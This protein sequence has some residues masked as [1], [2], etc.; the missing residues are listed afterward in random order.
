MTS[1]ALHTT[2]DSHG[3][4]AEEASSYYYGLPSKPELL[5]RTEKKQWSAPE[6]HK[7]LFPVSPHPIVHIWNDWAGRIDIIAIVIAIAFIAVTVVSLFLSP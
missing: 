1:P 3:V 4:S 7:E 2:P 6:G 5:Y